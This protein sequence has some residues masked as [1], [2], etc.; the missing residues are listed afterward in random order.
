MFLHFFSRACFTGL[1][2][3]FIQ[4]VTDRGKIEINFSR[5]YIIRNGR[6]DATPGPTISI[7][8]HTTSAR[9]IILCIDEM[10]RRAEFSG[11]RISIIVRIAG[12]TGHS[13]SRAQ[14]TRDISFA[15]RGEV[16][17]GDL[18]DGGMAENAPCGDAWVGGQHSRTADE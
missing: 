5:T 1:K 15:L 2:I 14:Q 9:R 12:N 17:A 10:I 13:Y 11:S 4:S 18:S 6:N 7:Q 3:P 8:I 16:I